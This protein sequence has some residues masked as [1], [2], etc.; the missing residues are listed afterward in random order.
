MVAEP[1][2]HFWSTVLLSSAAVAEICSEEDLEVLKSLLKVESEFDRDSLNF[3]V[4]FEFEENDFFTDRVL[5][6]SFIFDG[7]SGDHPIR[8]E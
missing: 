5:E 4:R 6:K 7:K 8:T 3:K 1:I 2:K